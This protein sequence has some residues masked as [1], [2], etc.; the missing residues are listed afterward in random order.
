MLSAQ[1]FNLGPGL[2]DMDKIED[3]KR[4]VLSDVANQMVCTLAGSEADSIG[5]SRFDRGP[6]DLR[7]GAYWGQWRDCLGIFCC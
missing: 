4:I 1:H 6:Q 5:W 3:N 2:C 7:Y